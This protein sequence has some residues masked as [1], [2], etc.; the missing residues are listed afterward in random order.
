MGQKMCATLPLL[1]HVTK[2]P[3]KENLPKH[4][5]DSNNICTFAIETNLIDHEQK[6]S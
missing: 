1:P 5:H 6:I 4:L 3:S 2:L